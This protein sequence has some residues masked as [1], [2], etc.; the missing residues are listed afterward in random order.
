MRWL[1]RNVVAH[2]RPIVV[3]TVIAIAAAATWGAGVS[4]RLSTGGNE[5]PGSDSVR[6]AELLAAADVPGSPNLVVLVRERSGLGPAAERAAADVVAELADV[7]GV[8]VAGSA[9][10]DDTGSVESSRTAGLRSEAGDAGL[11]VAHIE[12]GDPLVQA[13]SKEVLERL[14]GASWPGDVTVEIGGVGPTRL[15]LIETTDDDLVRAELLA[16]PFSVALLL[17]F[18]RTPVAAALPLVIAVVAIVGT[19]AVLRAL[20]EVVEVSIFARSVATALGLA[21]AIDMSLFLVARYREHR[22]AAPD[23][24]RAIELAITGA[25]PSILFSGLTTAVS[26]SSLLLFSTPMLRSFAYSGVAVVLLAIVGGLIVLPAVMTLLGDRIDRWALR[27]PNT[28]S[29]RR[30]RRVAQ[31]SMRRPLLVGGAVLLVLLLVASPIR[32]LEFGLNDDRVL[33]TS[34]ESRRVNEAIRSEF[35]G[36]EGAAISVVFAEGPPAASGS[37]EIDAFASSIEELNGVARVDVDAHALTVIPTVE[38]ISREGRALVEEVRALASP[39]PVVVGGEAAR[40]VDNTD[41]VTERLP[42]AIAVIVLGSAVLLAVLFRAVLATVK[43]IVL[44]L[45]SLAAMF[46]AIVWV[47]QDGRFA[48]FLGYTPVGLTD[49][50]VPMLMFA[51]AFGLSMDYEVY[52]LSRMRESYLVSG[53]AHASTVFGL[54]RTGR[55]LTASALLMAV[56]FTSF[57]TTSVAHLKVLGVGITLAVLVDAFVVRAMLVPAFMALAGTANWWPGGR[58][59]TRR[60]RLAAAPHAGS[61]GVVPVAADT[62]AA[63]ASNRPPRS[64]RE[65]VHEEERSAHRAAPMNSTSRPPRRP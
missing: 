17:L 22:P 51:L 16:I 54:E 19:L 8:V 43:A 25:G 63:Q 29:A 53:D 42:F 65:V 7:D 2:A 35:V 24:R 1:A 5:V 9:W 27:P 45:L 61:P 37:V 21:M 6:A 48:D 60:S 12:G 13:T 44:N 58:A 4:E 56:V 46:G 39:V 18:F 31:W 55:I 11:V 26:L 34:I 40:L 49:V 41:H 47:F 57:A 32:R 3:V 30:W 50:T 59:L 28:S 23:S 64:G 15:D 62:G 36:L 20:V 52:L 14:R 10:T 33:P 38:P